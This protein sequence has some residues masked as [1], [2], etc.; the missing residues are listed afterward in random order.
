MAQPWTKQFT[1]D[2]AQE[3][4]E[5]NTQSVVAVARHE[6]AFLTIVAYQGKF[7]AIMDEDIRNLG[8]GL[9]S[10]SQKKVIEKLLPVTDVVSFREFSIPREVD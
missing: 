7:W 2:N 3:A 1:I 8:V 10:L 6:Q 4:L 5:Y 9:N